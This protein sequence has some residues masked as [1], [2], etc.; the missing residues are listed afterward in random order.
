M[1]LLDYS[2]L[3]RVLSSF[4]IVVVLIYSIYYLINRYGKGVLPGQKGVIKIIDIKYLGKNKGLTVVKANGKYYFLSFDEKNISII[5]K[6][7]SLEEK[8]EK[9]QKDE[10]TP[11]NN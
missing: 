6:W 1:I 10:K 8:G 7:D 5:E 4:V 2:D 3:L 9:P 11:D